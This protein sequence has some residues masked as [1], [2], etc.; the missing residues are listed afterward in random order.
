MDRFGEIEKAAAGNQK[1]DATEAEM[2]IH[3]SAI[4]KIELMQPELERKAKE[5]IESKGLTLDRFQE[6]AAVIQQDQ[7]LQERLQ[8]IFI[9]NQGK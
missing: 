2:K 4:A 7:G 9:K 6:L 1:S 3:D 5:G 8:N